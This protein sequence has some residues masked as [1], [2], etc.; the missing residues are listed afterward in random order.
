MGADAAAS[1]LETTVGDT[2][3][4]HAG[5]V[6]RGGLLCVAYVPVDMV[7]AFVAGKTRGN[8]IVGGGLV[9]IAEGAIL[10]SSEKR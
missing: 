5:N 7:I 9:E 8:P 6:V 2:L 1:C 4:A 10:K 3:E